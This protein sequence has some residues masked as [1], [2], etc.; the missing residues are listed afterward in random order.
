MIKLQTSRFSWYGPWLCTIWIMTGKCCVPWPMPVSMCLLKQ[1]G[2][3][4]STMSGLARLRSSGSWIYV[5]KRQYQ[6]QWPLHY[7]RYKVKRE[8]ERHLYIC[9]IFFWLWLIHTWSFILYFWD[10]ALYS[11]AT[12]PWQTQNCHKY[13]ARLLHDDAT[14]SRLKL[15][16]EPWKANP[17]KKTEKIHGRVDPSIRSIKTCDNDLTMEHRT[18]E[19]V[20][21]K[22]DE[23][24]KLSTCKN[25]SQIMVNCC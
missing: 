6:K 24:F 16:T 9:L 5:A 12:W 22:H 11:S 21:T 14:S 23:A 20:M 17:R 4:F 18:L 10:S 3:K 25:Q 8:N 7:G 19:K 2:T 15:C 1:P 13:S